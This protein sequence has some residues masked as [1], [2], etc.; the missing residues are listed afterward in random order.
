[1]FVQGRWESIKEAIMSFEDEVDE[2]ILDRI[3]DDVRMEV[4][5]VEEPESFPWFFNN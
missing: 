5:E 4:E 2:E 1:M 3:A